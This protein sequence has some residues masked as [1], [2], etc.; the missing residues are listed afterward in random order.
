MQ[1]PPTAR[2]RLPPPC[3]PEDLSD[4]FDFVGRLEFDWS[5]FPNWWAWTP[6][7]IYN[8]S[9]QLAQY[10]REAG[11]VSNEQLARL[12]PAASGER[13]R[14]L[15][16]TSLEQLPKRDNQSRNKQNSS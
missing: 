1:R 7:A 5:T 8:Y 15:Q 11:K 14:R 4:Y 2:R 16:L 12:E 13:P 6:D 9:V 10:L 3:R